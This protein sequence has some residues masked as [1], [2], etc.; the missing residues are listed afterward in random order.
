MG[1]EL[2]SLELVMRAQ[3]Q[4]HGYQSFYWGAVVYGRDGQNQIIV[5]TV[6]SVRLKAKAL[7]DGK[8]R[9]ARFKLPGFRDVIRI[10]LFPEGVTFDVS[11]RSPSVRTGDGPRDPY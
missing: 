6:G 4:G 10:E 7:T 1:L 11:V 2:P 9:R 8:P 3:V 5:R